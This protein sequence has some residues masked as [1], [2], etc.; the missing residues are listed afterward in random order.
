MGLTFEQICIGL[1]G[2]HI[3]VEFP[4]E[5]IPVA[6]FKSQKR[7]QLKGQPNCD[8]N[9]WQENKTSILYILTVFQTN[10]EGLISELL[11]I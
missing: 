10:K 11:W 2:Q 4:P 1:H 8:S 6:H 5:L 9:D 3:I 7:A